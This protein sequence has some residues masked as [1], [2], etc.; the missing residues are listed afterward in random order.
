MSERKLQNR[1]TDKK[2]RKEFSKI[3]KKLSQSLR[4]GENI[5]EYALL[6]SFIEEI[7]K[8][9]D[10]PSSLNSGFRL[11]NFILSDLKKNNLPK[12]FNNNLKNAKFESF[13]QNELKVLGDITKSTKLKKNIKSNEI[14]MDILNLK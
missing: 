3:E 6:N 12:K 11:A 9:Q 5:K 2:F 14:Q 4:K 1:I 10:N 7:N 8:L 13:T